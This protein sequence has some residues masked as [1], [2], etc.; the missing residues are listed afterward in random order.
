MNAAN[1]IEIQR[2]GGQI[3][4]RSLVIATS[5]SG[6]GGQGRRLSDVAQY[7]AR[8]AVGGGVG[9]GAAREACVQ[10]CVSSDMK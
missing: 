7:R 6:G 9:G 4:L 2:R 1:V 8:P 10:R 3:G 5:G